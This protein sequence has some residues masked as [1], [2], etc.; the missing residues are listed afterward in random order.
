MAVTYIGVETLVSRLLLN[1]RN[2]FNETALLGV[3][4]SDIPF[5]PDQTA[6]LGNK[7]LL[8][9]VDMAPKILN[10]NV[11]TYEATFDKTEANFEWLEW[12]LFNSESKPVMFNRVQEYSGTKLPGQRW[13]LKID[14]TFNIGGLTWKK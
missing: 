7:Q 12:G 10:G 3:G 5:S 13:V 9:T 4:N 2:T 14:L 1:D 8:K 6:L 11:I